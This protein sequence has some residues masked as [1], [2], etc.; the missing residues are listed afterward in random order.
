MFL[1]VNDRGIS[2]TLLLFGRREED[3]RRILNRVLRK[4]M[5]V[6]DIGANIGYYVLMERSLIGSDGHI[7]AIEP[8][9]SNTELLMQNVEANGYQNV[10]VRQAAV[11]DR[12]GK[13]DLRLSHMS[14][15][16]SFHDEGSASRFFSGEVVSV[17]TFTVPMLAESMGPPDFIRMDVEGHE[18][19][20][21]NGLVPAVEAGKMAPMILF[22]THRS[23]YTPDHDIRGPLERLFRA[24]YTVPFVASSTEDGAEKMVKMG[25]ATEGLFTT[26]FQRRAIFEKLK[27][28]DLIDMVC[29]EGGIRTVLLAKP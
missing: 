29:G 22:E 16:N 11:S 19:E 4:G 24:G 8:S 28:S 13:R 7:L 3:H 9:P 25:Y 20:I 14:N 18:V 26:D 17:E 12:A 10:T 23:T 21:L 6:F 15:L 5:N 27:P 1:D 2:R